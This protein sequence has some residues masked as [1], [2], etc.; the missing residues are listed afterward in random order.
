MEHAL[1]SA[2]ISRMDSLDRHPPQPDWLAYGAQTIAPRSE[3]TACAWTG[4]APPSGGAC[5]SS[6]RVVLVRN[7]RW[8]P[9]KT[10]KYQHHCAQIW[11]VALSTIAPTLKQ[12]CGLAGYCRVD[13]LVTSKP[14]PGQREH[15]PAFLT[16]QTPT[17]LGFYLSEWFQ[18][19]TLPSIA[20]PLNCSVSFIMRLCRISFFAIFCLLVVVIFWPPSKEIAGAENLAAKPPD[21]S[22]LASSP[23]PEI[24]SEKKLLQQ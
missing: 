24:T 7:H 9:I 4:T 21:I 11:A 16:R 5:Q 2:T 14:K 10:P 18:A 15:L 1:S 13:C 22:L 19:E 12:S 23:P 3:A 8:P 17:V 20:S 6:D